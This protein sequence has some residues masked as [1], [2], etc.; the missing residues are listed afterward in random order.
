MISRTKLYLSTA[1]S[2]LGGLVSPG[3]N[4]ATAFCG[5]TTIQ[6]LREL[7]ASPTKDMLKDHV[8][9]FSSLVNT[10]AISRETVPLL[11]L[12]INGWG[13]LSASQR[14][15]AAVMIVAGAGAA[16]YSLATFGV[17]HNTLASGLAS[18]AAV[19][20]FNAAS[21][22]MSIFHCNR[23]KALQGSGQFERLPNEG[24]HEELT[25][26]GVSQGSF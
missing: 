14:A 13:D 4:L 21:T 10:Y 16:G 19:T 24:E 2:A 11:F 8:S 22:M 17:E 18:V 6:M 3:F 26:V 25:S 9:H 7:D 1:T 15:S 5:Y 23:I 20:S 12:L